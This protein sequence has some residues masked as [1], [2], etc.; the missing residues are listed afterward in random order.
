M[1]KKNWK[2]VKGQ[3]WSRFATFDT[4]DKFSGPLM[5]RHVFISQYC[6]TSRSQQINILWRR[7]TF[8]FTGPAVFLIRQVDL[9]LIHLFLRWLFAD[10]RRIYGVS[11]RP[12]SVPFIYVYIYQLI[13]SLL[14][15]VFTRIKLCY[16]KGTV[17]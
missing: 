13:N 14:F 9:E 11:Y 5:T 6:V 4:V 15:A 10:H 3:S 2:E 7:P 17:E 16:R 1:G 12:Y 8:G